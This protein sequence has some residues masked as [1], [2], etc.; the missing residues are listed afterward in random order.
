VAVAV[1]VVVVVV[2]V[3]VA[4]AVAVVV[5]VAVVRSS[6]LQI[7]SAPGGDKQT[8]IQTNTQ[9]NKQTMVRSLIFGCA[10]HLRLL[11]CLFVKRS[12]A[13]LRV[14]EVK[15]SLLGFFFVLFVK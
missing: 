10:C 4:V 15:F 1:A 2:A 9:T 3:A 11:F 14:C 13:C 7:C 5:V 8:N 12:I 6:A